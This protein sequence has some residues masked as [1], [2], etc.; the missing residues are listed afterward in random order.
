MVAM[1]RQVGMSCEINAAVH[2]VNQRQRFRFWNKISEH[3]GGNLR[4]RKL[5][6]WGVAFKPGTDDIREAPSLTLMEQALIHG[7]KVRAFDPVAGENLQRE[8][9]GVEMCDDA[10]ETL[11]DCDALIVCTEWSEF[12]QV[13]LE[14]IGEALGEKVIFDGRNI[15]E[16]E[17][18]RQGG[19]TYHSIGRPAV[20]P[21]REPM[22]VAS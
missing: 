2:S 13:D 8:L 21:E 16:P 17:K 20:V 12:H 4:G 9:P 11:R 14:A 1:G 6:F 7:A 10:F 15:Y 18:M 22:A 19:F 5:A 3:F